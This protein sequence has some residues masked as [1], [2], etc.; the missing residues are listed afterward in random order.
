MEVKNIKIKIND[1]EKNFNLLNDFLFTKIFGE[2]GCE[3]ETLHLINIF[4]EKNFK[5]LSY[6]P[7]EMKG[8][9]EGHKRVFTDVLVV[10]NDHTIVNIEAQN[11]TQKNFHKR[12]YFYK[13]RMHSIFLSV[14]QDH[15]N[16]Q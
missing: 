13:T 16:Y 7:T 10:M 8:V 9:H 2:R 1:K 15:K 11:Y 4:T 3:K 6:E 12:S 5:T 14:G